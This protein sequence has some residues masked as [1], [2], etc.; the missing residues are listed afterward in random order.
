MCGTT[1]GF[2]LSEIDLELRGAGSILGSRQSG[3]SDLRVASI[4]GDRDILNAARADARALLAD[5]P[6]LSRHPMLR[7]EVHAA[8]GPDAQAWL[9][10]S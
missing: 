9:E 2:V 7:G 1:D 10:R 5:D 8:L 4:L 3:L 6:Q